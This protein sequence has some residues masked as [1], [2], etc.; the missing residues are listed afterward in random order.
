M[1]ANRAAFDRSG[2][3]A[4]DAAR[5]HRARRSTTV[6]GTAMP[7]PLL[8]APVGVQSILH[9]DGELATARAAAALGVPMVLSTASSHTIEDVAAAAGTVRAGTSSTGRS[10]T[11]SRSAPRPGSRRRVRRARRHARHLDAGLAP[12]RPRRAPTCRSCAGSAPRSRSPTR[13]SGPGSPIRP[14]TTW[15]RRSRTG[16]DLH[17]APPALGHGWTAARRVGRPD[18]AQGH[19]AP[20]RRRAALD[21]GMDGVIVSNHGGARS[22]ARSGRSRAAGGRRGGRR[23][24]RRCCSTPASGP[25]PTPQ[26]AGPRRRRRAARPSVRLRPG[27]RRARPGS[28][29]CCA[30]AGRAGHHPGLA[31]VADLAGL[32]AARDPVV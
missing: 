13:P 15:R 4:A 21:A 31:G 11:T 2:A 26:G 32:R 20:R 16:R 23:D 3:G 14:R 1:R 28:A 25:G 8:L 29:T 30:A 22:T 6:L 24:G 19:P 18:R 9:P 17:R 12:A 10:T 5:Q 7:A 27:A